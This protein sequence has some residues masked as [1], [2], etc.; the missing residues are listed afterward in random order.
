VIGS[1]VNVSSYFALARDFRAYAKAAP[2]GNARRLLGAD[3]TLQALDNGRNGVDRIKAA[4]TKLRDALAA[5]RAEADAVPGR[6]ALKPV[7]AEVEQTVDKPTFVTIN[8]QPVQSGT[9]TVSLGPRPLVVG[10]ERANRA[11]LAVGDALRS[12]AATVASLVSGVGAAGTGGLAAD[13]SALLRSDAFTTAVNR[14]D[15]AAIDTAIGRI[16]ATL[17]KTEGLGFSLGT[18]A[19]AAAQV[20][21]GG[22]LLGAA[23]NAGAGASGVAGSSGDSS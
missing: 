3:A 1:V 8:G 21:L 17:A 10:Y 23:P 2:G 12:L 4:L 6:T 5:A 7:V 22:L 13:V 15:A 11:P 18:R 16:D 9:I 14:P 19:A 20:D